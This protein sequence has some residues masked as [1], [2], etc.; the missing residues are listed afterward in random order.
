MRRLGNINVNVLPL[1]GIAL[2]IMSIVGSYRGLRKLD[3]SIEKREQYVLNYLRLL[4]GGMAVSHTSAALWNDSWAPQYLAQ[5][6]TNAYPALVEI[7]AGQKGYSIT[8]K[9]HELMAAVD[10]NLAPRLKKRQ[11][12]NPNW[13]VAQIIREEDLR[14]FQ[15]GLDRYN[16]QQGAGSIDLHALIG[17]LNALLGGTVNG[18]Q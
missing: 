4:Q 13:T 1:F 15:T 5:A 10:K 6:T 16:Q 18:S 9:G 2:A 12:S 14:E 17:V 11:A 3:K 8:K 7:P